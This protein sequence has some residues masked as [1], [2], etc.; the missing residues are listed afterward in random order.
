M[1]L[2]VQGAGYEHY[3]SGPWETVAD[4]SPHQRANPFNPKDNVNIFVSGQGPVFVNPAHLIG[5]A[6]R[7]RRRQVSIG[8]RVGRRRGFER[9]AADSA[10]VRPAVEHL[11]GLKGE[12]S[13]SFPRMI[14]IPTPHASAFDEGLLPDGAV[15]FWGD[16]EHFKAW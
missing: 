3:E 14:M 8:D 1:D 6:T 12:S 4:G 13:F 5:E 9:S 11:A 15:E 7:G 2:Q 10:G 16:W